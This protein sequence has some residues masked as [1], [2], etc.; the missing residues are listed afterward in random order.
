MGLFLGLLLR[1][2]LWTLK[3]RVEF[4]PELDGA[5]GP[6]V[7]SFFH[8]T[9]FPLLAWRRPRPT[10][11]LVSLSSDG[12]LQAGLLRAAGL[13]VVRGSSSRGGARGLAA[14]VRRIKGGWD[15]A[16][17][18]DGPRGPR[19]KVKGGALLA[20]RATRALLVPMGS[21]VA[22]GKV[23][24]RAWDRYALPWPFSRVT[25]VLGA[26]LPATCTAEELER[27]I[28]GANRRAGAL[29][30]RSRAVPRLV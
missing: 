9:Q 17:A 26:P 13:G 24:E 27:A 14:L 19:G 15:A 22:R 10:V 30:P 18:V 20:A 5:R 3:L 21:A 16:F 2:W 11:T 12:S 25:V 1:L 7:L 28:E 4:H 23:F 6:W 8:G 29:L